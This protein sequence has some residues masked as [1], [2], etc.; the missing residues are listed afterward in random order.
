MSNNL[1]QNIGAISLQELANTIQSLSDR[2]SGIAP[3]I[4][5]RLREERKRLRKTQ[6]DFANIGGVKRLA[7]VS[8]EKENTDPSLAYLSR[9]AAAGA[10]LMYLIF[11]IRLIPA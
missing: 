8:Y 6:A 11:G 4:G 9:I 7:Q 5:K 2:T 3:G 10:D 1:P